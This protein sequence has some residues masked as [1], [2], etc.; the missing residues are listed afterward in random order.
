MEKQKG[1]ATIHDVAAAAGV[2]IATVSRAINNKDNVK[3][4]TYKRIMAAIR[5]VGYE[6]YTIKHT[7]GLILVLLPDI[8]NPF[9]S[10]VVKGISSAAG[11]HGY[12]E[13]IVRTGS[14]PLTFDFVENLVYTTSAEGVITLDPIESDML[15]KMCAKFP[16]VQCAECH[17]ASHA[18]YVTIDDISASE[19][20]VDYIVSKGITRIALL[21]GPMKYKY[22]R[23]RQEGFVKGL[24]KHN[25]EVDPYLLAPL[26]VFSYDAAVSLSTQLL[27]SP[28]PPKAIFAV[29][30]V[31]AVA[32]VNA[33][34]R[35][36]LKI[37][38]DLG[39]IG[40]DNTETSVMCT[41]PLTT[42]KQPQ[43]QMGFLASE[44]LIEQINNP[45]T[46]P[47]HI[48]LKTELIIRESI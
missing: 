42:V 27:T 22:S 8:K 6:K 41:P 48:M 39:V 30:D 25:I 44:M 10:E 35:L 47:K 33:A 32:A 26:P 18:S 37:P 19:L 24:K 13:I 45:N 43:Y 2:S 23:K 7:S 5:D 15:K 29:S 11:R 9:Y 21:N 38:E 4:P 40:F 17:E 46:V 28:S 12:Q 14:H 36:G 20:V 16:M 34:K 1:K 31:F 3:P